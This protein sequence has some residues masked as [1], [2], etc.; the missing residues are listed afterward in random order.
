MLQQCLSVTATILVVS[1]L[2]K[3]LVETSETSLLSKGRRLVERAMEWKERGDEEG[4]V[5][6]KYQYYTTAFAF[7]QAGRECAS[8]SELE[9]A[10]SID[11]SS[12]WT[13]IQEG[14][15]K[16]R[17]NARLLPCKGR[18]EVPKRG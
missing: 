9:R 7:L 16:A 10:T 2:S 18:G 15:T 1:I 4:D 5:I 11:M 6:L 3:I 17:Q 13:R 8:D 12:V 14:M